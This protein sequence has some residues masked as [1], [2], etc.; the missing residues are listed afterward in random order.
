MELNLD[1]KK[2]PDKDSIDQQNKVT[3]LSVTDVA[4]FLQLPISRIRYEI[5]RKNIPF[6]KIGRSIRFHLSDIWSWL[7]T[8]RKPFALNKNIQIKEASWK[9][10][11]FNLRSHQDENEFE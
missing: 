3:L 5:F 9:N 4:N 11:E 7:E 2:T 10:S 8:Q 1:N 6:Y